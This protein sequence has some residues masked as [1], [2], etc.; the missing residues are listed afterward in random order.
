MRNTSIPKAVISGILATLVMT[1]LTFI[2]PMMGMPEMN[3]PKMLS[4]T[5]GLPLIAGWIAHFMTG[6]MLSL[7]YASVFYHLLSGIN[8]VKG[9]VFSL[10]PWLMAQLIVVPMMSVMNGMSFTSGIFSGSFLMAAGSLMGHLVYG[11]ILGI[12]YYPQSS[13]VPDDSL[14]KVS[15]SKR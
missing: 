13:V 9:M 7:L 2:A 14:S 4:M 6:I 15:Y 1:I 11:L 12:L 5:M 3:I 10:I 8:A